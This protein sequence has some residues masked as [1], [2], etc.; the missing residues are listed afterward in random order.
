MLY[1]GGTCLEDM[2]M[3]E[4]PPGSRPMLLLAPA[5]IQTTGRARLK[6]TTKDARAT[7]GAAAGVAT[8]LARIKALAEGNDPARAEQG[9]DDAKAVAHCSSPRGLGAGSRFCV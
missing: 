6:A 8:F 2:A 1:A 3:L 9:K 5:F 4:P 7:H